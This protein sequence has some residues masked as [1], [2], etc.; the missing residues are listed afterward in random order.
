MTMNIY[1]VTI[2]Q[3]VPQAQLLKDKFDNST[4][5]NHVNLAFH[6]WLENGKLHD[7][8]WLVWSSGSAVYTKDDWCGWRGA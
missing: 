3:G 7:V 2:R 5:I 1:G 8:I 6:V 4:H